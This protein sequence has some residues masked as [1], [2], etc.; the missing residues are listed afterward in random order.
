MSDLRVQVI[1]VMEDYAKILNPTNRGWKVLEVGIAGDEKPG[2]NYKLYGVGND[3]KTLD[4]VAS[5]EPDIVADICSTGLPPEEW[6]IIIVSQTLEHIYDFEKPFKECY[7]LLKP[8]GHLIIDCPFVYPYHPEPEFGDYF[9]ISPSAMEK[10][11]L[12]A[13]FEI[14][15]LS[16]VNGILT[17][18]L[19]CKPNY[20]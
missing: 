1:Q 11:V 20:V 8:S 15:K 7:R 13:G 18:A 19:V 17:T 5:Y 6:D 4:V 16:L 12:D 3:Y 2:G 14:K 10:L 9:R